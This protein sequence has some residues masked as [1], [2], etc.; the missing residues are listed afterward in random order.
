M[1]FVNIH[2]QKLIE[3]GAETNLC[4]ATAENCSPESE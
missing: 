1:K 3:I 4:V 2:T